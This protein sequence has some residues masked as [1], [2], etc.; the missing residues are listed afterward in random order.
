M[1]Y[2]FFKE[3]QESC[4]Q[5]LDL[6]RR[7]W[8][9][10]GALMLFF[11]SSIFPSSQ[12]NHYK[13]LKKVLK[14]FV[15]LTRKFWI[16]VFLHLILCFFKRCAIHRWI[17][18]SFGVVAGAQKLFVVFC[19]CPPLPP[20]HLNVVV[21]FYCVAPK[22]ARGPRGPVA[23]VASHKSSIIVCYYG[24]DSLI[25][26]F[27]FSANFEEGFFFF[28]FSFSPACLSQTSFAL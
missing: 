14:V 28:F 26:R 27:A 3:K 13:P 16:F 4:F 12:G 24:G 8:W 5:V 1:Q 20:P 2:F 23:M 9:R 22:Q 21:N 15:D 19:V 18:I 10:W 7:W 6:L 17:E 11:L 25:K